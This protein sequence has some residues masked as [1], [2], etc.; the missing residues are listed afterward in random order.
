[1]AV[2]VDPP[3]D[4]SAVFKPPVDAED[5]DPAPLDVAEGLLLELE[6]DEDAADSSPPLPVH[7]ELVEDAGFLFSCTDSARS[8]R[9]PIRRPY[10]V[11]VKVPSPV[12]AD[13][14]P[15]HISPSCTIVS[16][17]S[18]EKTSPGFRL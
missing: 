5:T 8:S 13:R 12:V 4:D 9:T 2:D 17:P 11:T 10:G 14:V 3:P 15:I 16:T 18:F 7:T 6:D 1:M